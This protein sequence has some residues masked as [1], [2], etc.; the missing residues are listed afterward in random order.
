MLRLAPVQR[1]R[2]Q[3]VVA[4]TAEWRLRQESMVGGVLFAEAATTGTESHMGAGL[5]VRIRLPPQ[6]ANTLRFDFGYGSS[7]WNA[8]AGIGEFF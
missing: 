4:G 2:G 6:P 7:G 8:F 3:E 5:G 1:Y